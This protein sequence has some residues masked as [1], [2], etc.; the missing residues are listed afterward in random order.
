[1]PGQYLTV[2]H[3]CGHVFSLP[4]AFD[5]KLGT[6][7]QKDCSNLLQLVLGLRGQLLFQYVPV[8]HQN[9]KRQAWLNCPEKITDCCC[10]CH[11]YLRKKSLHFSPTRCNTLDFL[12][13]CLSVFLCLSLMVWQCD[14]EE[15]TSSVLWGNV[16]RSEMSVLAPLIALCVGVCSCLSEFVACVRIL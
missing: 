3:Q 8:K 5:T 13:S 10:A 11:F 6:W 16:S 2:L 15:E 7:Y 4:S 1:M 12:S 9:I 14:S